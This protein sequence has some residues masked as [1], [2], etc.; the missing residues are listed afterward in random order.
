[1]PEKEFPHF[2]EAHSINQIAID[3]QNEARIIFSIRLTCKV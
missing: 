2:G 1:M 3:S